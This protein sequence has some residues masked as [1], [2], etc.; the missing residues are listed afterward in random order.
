MCSVPPHCGSGR[1][2]KNLNGE[3]VAL[4]DYISAACRRSKKAMFIDTSPSLVN[5][6]GSATKIMFLKYDHSRVHLNNTG[7]EVISTIMA[8]LIN[9]EDKET[10]ETKAK[11]KS[12]S[13]PVAIEHHAIKNQLTGK[14]ENEHPSAKSVAAR[15]L[16]SASVPLSDPLGT[17]SST[18]NTPLTSDS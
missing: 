12:S 5:T 8:H 13:S 14:N 18:S 3:T 17:R 10:E 16:S 7:V 1:Q 2:L 15:S 9:H 6:D 11:R 4:N